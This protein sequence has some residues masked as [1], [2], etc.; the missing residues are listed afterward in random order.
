M[1]RELPELDAAQTQVLQAIKDGKSK[2]EAARIAQVARRSVSYW[3]NHDGPLVPHLKAWEDDRRRQQDIV[4]SNARHALY[5]EALRSVQALADIR[6]DD[7]APAH[8]R[9]QASTQILDRVG[10][11][12]TQRHEVSGP[13]GG[14]IDFRAAVV[15][16]GAVLEGASLPQLEAIA[17]QGGEDVQGE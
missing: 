11:T 17:F 2:T 8:V 12:S 6:D 1:S 9:M 4:T 7:Q 10:I 3:C 16:M 14:P 13:D 15:H 5:V